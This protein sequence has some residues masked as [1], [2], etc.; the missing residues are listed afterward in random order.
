MTEKAFEELFPS[1]PKKKI[2]P[3]NTGYPQYFKEEIEKACLD[4]ERVHQAIECGRQL[5]TA[6][7]DKM[8]AIDAFEEFMRR[9][10]RL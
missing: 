1:L 10:L 3:G 8:E 6:F 9:E 5:A 4:K 2:G 7:K